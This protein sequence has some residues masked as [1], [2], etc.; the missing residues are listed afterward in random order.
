MSRSHN[1]KGR[2]TDEAFQAME[3]FLGGGW[4]PT[5]ADFGL[6]SFRNPL[7]AQE[8]MAMRKK[9]KEA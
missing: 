6:F 9:K 5:W 4:A 7:R 2:T 3:I 8:R 1:I